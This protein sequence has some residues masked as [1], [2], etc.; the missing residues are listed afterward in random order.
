MF[1]LRIFAAEQQSC[2]FAGRG[3]ITSINNYA[4][5]EYQIEA[6]GHTHTHTRAYGENG[7]TLQVIGDAAAATA[8]AAVQPPRAAI[9]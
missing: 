1:N 6:Q 5:P 9:D 8:A 4:W 3:H 7:A 2:G